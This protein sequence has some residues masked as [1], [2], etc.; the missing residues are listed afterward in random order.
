MMGLW[1]KKNREEAKMWASENSKTILAMYDV[2]NSVNYIQRAAPI[3]MG[4]DVIEQVLIRS[5]RELRGIKQNGK[6]LQLELAKATSLVRFG[7]ENASSSPAIKSKREK[8]FQKRL[9]VSNPFQDPDIKKRM[10]Q[11]KIE[12][13]G[14]PNPA[15]HA[16]R[17]RK[18][19]SP[20]KKLSAKLI[21]HGI[22]HL[23][24]VVIYNVEVFSKYKAPRVDIL[25]GDLAIEVFGD[26]YHANP[27][28]YLPSD[29]ISLFKGK[30]E[31]QEIWAADK[32]RIEK[33]N[34]CGFKTMVIWEFEIKRN[35]DIVIE[36]IKDELGN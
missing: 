29:L 16:E 23:N 12:R 11:I 8:T 15:C 30:K 18:L 2:G 31:A 34:V 33:L 9:G 7:Y 10:E 17:N 3:K 36:R 27:K 13:Y 21:E 24:E 35:L 26:Y 5:G 25:I 1:L 22:E 28:K 4:R 14:H 32:L 6:S 20:H 19:S